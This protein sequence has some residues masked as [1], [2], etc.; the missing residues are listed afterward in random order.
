M[1]D[2]DQIVSYNGEEMR[3]ADIPDPF[4]REMFGMGH[5]ETYGREVITE[6]D[7]GPRKWPFQVHTCL[8]SGEQF[9]T[10]WV[11]NGE[12]LVCIGCGLD[13]T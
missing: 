12:I 5:A 1:T 9:A 2:P 13:C 10:E 3:I 4:V 8:Y 7:S 11:R 6:D